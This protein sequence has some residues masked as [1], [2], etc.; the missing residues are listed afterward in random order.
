MQIAIEM[1]WPVRLYVTIPIAAV[2]DNE[3]D[4]DL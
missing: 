1:D 3:G 4:G 2:V